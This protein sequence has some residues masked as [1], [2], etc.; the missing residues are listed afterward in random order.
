[1]KL[2]FVGLLESEAPI[3]SSVTTKTRKGPKPLAVS[4][5]GYTARFRVANEEKPP[6]IGELK[7]EFKY[8]PMLEFGDWYDWSFIEE[9]L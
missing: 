2:K 1:M 5:L 3:S 9:L 7:L 4:Y 8:I 6:Y